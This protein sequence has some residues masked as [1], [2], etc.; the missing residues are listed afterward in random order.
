MVNQLFVLDTYATTAV[1]CQ[2]QID[3]VSAHT[4]SQNTVVRHRRTTALDVAQHSCAGFTTGFFLDEMRQF[5]NI[6]HMF[7]NRHD[8]V[9]FTFRDTRFDFVYQVFTA[10]FNFR[11][12]NEFTATGNSRSQ[13]QIA[14]ITAHHFHHGNTLVRRRGVTQTVDRFYN[15]AQR[16]EETDSV[17]SAFDVVV[18]STRQADARE[19]H[20][21]QTHCTHVGTVTADNHQRIDPT[22]FQVF[23]S[24]GADVLVAEFRETRRTE[25]RTA[26]VDH[27]RNAVTV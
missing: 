26:T 13:R 10:E 12:H 21:G 11:N 7:G 24:H 17:V 22:F 23:D 25:E 3:S 5:V 4:G 9:F 15:G 19:A 8:R 14:T 2:Q 18:D 27:V 20:F 16:S 1:T 6:T